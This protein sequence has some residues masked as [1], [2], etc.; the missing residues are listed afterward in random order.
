MLRQKIT[1]TVIA[2]GALVLPLVQT[3]SVSAWGPERQTYTMDSPAN[4]P[5]FNSIT[6]NSKL[7]DERDFV[8]IVEKGSGNI[9]TSELEIEADK[10]YIVAIYYHNNASATYN[11]EAHGH[12]GVAEN[13]RVISYFPNELSAGERGKIDGVITASNA[14]PQTVWDEAYITAKEN[15]KIG[16]VEGTAKIYNSWGVNGADLSMDIFTRRGAFIGLDALNGIIL[17][18]DEYS[19]MIYYDIRTVAEDDPLP[20][21]VDPIDP[22]P[23]VDPEPSVT[24]KDPDLPSE[25]PKTG[26]REVA[27]AVIVIVLVAAGLVYWRHSR[28]VAKKLANRSKG[29]KGKK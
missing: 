2:L 13:T 17:G 11:D 15:L 5:V 1:K 24:P 25:L 3:A 12:V 18:C 23:I 9:F 16:Y 8:R 19:G 29:K 10:E 21:D 27:F 20:P 6:D 28:N 14:D 4:H 22:E 26:P 7:G